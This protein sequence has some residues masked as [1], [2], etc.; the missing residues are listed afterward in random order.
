MRLPSKTN[1]V[2]SV[3]V[4]KRASYI[5][6][7]GDVVVFE[8]DDEFFHLTKRIIGL[9][10]DTVE[11]RNGIVRVND[12]DLADPYVAVENRDLELDVEK[13]VVPTGHMYVMGDNRN[14]SIDSRVFGTVPAS[15][16]R[17]QIAFIYSPFARSGSVQ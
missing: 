9:G 3:A 7:R 14:N 13:I 1:N 11:I 8:N 5:P 4:R 16:V 2:S 12:V 15:S 6:N 10:G 17:G